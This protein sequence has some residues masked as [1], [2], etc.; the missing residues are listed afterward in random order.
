MRPSTVEII[1]IIRV[2]ANVTKDI[3][4]FKTFNLFQFCSP[5]FGLFRF[6]LGFVE[7]DYC[8]NFLP[9]IQIF[10]IAAISRL[11]IIGRGAFRFEHIRSILRNFVSNFTV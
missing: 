8:L 2:C 5:L 11:F 1:E 9:L 4:L 6:V 10:S 3:S 7:V